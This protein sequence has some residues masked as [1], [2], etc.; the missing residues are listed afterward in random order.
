MK[1]YIAGWNMPGYLPEI[2]PVE[3]DSFKEAKKYIV[4][5]LF[6]YMHELYDAGE[7]DDG[8]AEQTEIEIL[9]LEEL[10]YDFNFRLG[11]YI[12]WTLS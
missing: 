9:I 6:R 4:E 10:E 8:E 3:F 7:L 11:D 12:F 5:E 2:E 1:R